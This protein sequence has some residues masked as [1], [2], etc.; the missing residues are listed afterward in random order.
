MKQ[1]VGNIFLIWRKGQG[2][3][4]IIVGIIK[5]NKTKGARF[6]YDLKGVEEA[7]KDGFDC[8]TDF[9]DTSIEYTEKVLDVFGQRLNKSE[10]EDIQKYYDFWEIDPKHKNDKYYLLAHTQGIMPTDNFEFLA[11]YSPARNL[12]FVSEISGLS[13]VQLPSDIIEEGELLRW[14]K[15]PANAYD[16]FAV[17]VFK[18]DTLLGYVKKVHSRVFY[19][20]GGNRLRIQAKNISKNGHL[21]RVFIKIYNPE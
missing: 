15:E 12:R 21:N 5:N 9:P 3:R 4:R 19:K 16:E 20:H 10:R 18:G 1:G 6:V 17:K 8:Y 7:K 11:N 2:S 13:Q 14:E